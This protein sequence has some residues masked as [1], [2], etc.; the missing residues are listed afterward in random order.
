MNTNA[1]VSVISWIYSELR[2]ALQA[3]TGEAEY[4]R[5]R[6]RCLASGQPPLDPGRYLAERLDARYRST[7]RCC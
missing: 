3:W 4:Q 7:S 2:W 6:Q 5:Y 1:V